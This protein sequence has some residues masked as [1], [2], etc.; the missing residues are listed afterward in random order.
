MSASRRWRRGGARARCEGRGRTFN[1]GG[2][3]DA[4]GARRRDAPSGAHSGLT[5]TPTTSAPRARRARRSDRTFCGVW[6]GE[7]AGRFERFAR[8]SDGARAHSRGCVRRTRRGALDGR[9]A[10]APEADHEDSLALK[11]DDGT[12]GDGGRR[13]R[14]VA[15]GAGERGEPARRDRARTRRAGAASTRRERR[16][17]GARESAGERALSELAPPDTGRSSPSPSAW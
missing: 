1:R 8:T 17:R 9:R 15:D 2:G 6:F 7:R 13:R 11:I 4:R 5:S 12:V 14:V 16:S 10:D 3:D